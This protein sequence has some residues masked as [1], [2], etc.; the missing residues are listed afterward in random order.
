MKTPKNYSKFLKEG[1]C[2]EQML[3]DVIY[4]YNK[5]AKNF[6]DKVW[7]HSQCYWYKSDWITKEEERRDAYYEKKERLIKT[8]FLS[9]A[10]CIHKHTIYK[11]R[12]VY[13][14]QKNYDNI[15][16]YYHSNCYFDRDK[17]DYVYFKDY[18]ETIDNYYLCTE[19]GDRLF[20]TPIDIRKE[21][22]PHLEVKELPDDFYTYGASVKELLSVQFCDKVYEKFINSDKCAQCA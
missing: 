2:D 20:H 17:E 19:I 10:K 12:R 13:D 6:R 14:Y 5:R 7:E 16:D 18:N 15:T 3:S 9:N 4:S 21:K 8:L 1:I 11:K 22:F